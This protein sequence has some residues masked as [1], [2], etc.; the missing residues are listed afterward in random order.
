MNY[1]LVIV[2]F[3]SW[4]NWFSLLVVWVYVWV[5]GIGSYSVDDLINILDSILEIDIYY[6]VWI[7]NGIWLNLEKLIILEGIDNCFDIGCFNDGWLYL[8][9]VNV[10]V[11][12]IEGGI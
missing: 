6:F 9:W 11:N 2:K 1:D 7:G 5:D 8:V 3:I 10:E 12:V 4:D